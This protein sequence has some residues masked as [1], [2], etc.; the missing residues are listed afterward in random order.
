VAGLVITVP[1]IVA[2]VS[3]ARLSVRP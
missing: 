2:S 1:V 3:L